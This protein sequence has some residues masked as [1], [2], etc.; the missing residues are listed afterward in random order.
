MRPLSK[1]LVA[2]CFA[3]AVFSLAADATA[4]NR[5]RRHHR[6]K[7]K[8]DRPVPAIPEPT[9]ALAFAAGLLAVTAATRKRPER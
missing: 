8:I 4:G 3:V 5:H 1:A 2:T 9:G 6:P 7:P